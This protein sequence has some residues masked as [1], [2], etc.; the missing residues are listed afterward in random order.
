MYRYLYFLLTITPPADGIFHS[1]GDTIYYSGPN[2]QNHTDPVNPPGGSTSYLERSL[3]TGR[4][5]R[6][7]R[8]ADRKG[9]LPP[10]VGIRYDGLY[11]LIGRSELANTKGGL[12][13]RYVLKRQDG[14]EALSDIAKRSPTQQQIT[15]FNR[16]NEFW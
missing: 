1:H 13:V 15:D 2:S 12:F 10:S 11:Q 7:L 9:T 4:P 14:Q 8:A 16:K 5:V 3:Q 6:V